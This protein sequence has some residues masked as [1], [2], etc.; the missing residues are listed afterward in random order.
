[1]KIARPRLLVGSLAV[2]ALVPAKAIE[3]YDRYLLDDLLDAAFASRALDTT[4]AWEALVTVRDDLLRKTTG[5]G[6]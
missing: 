2:A 5:D 1:V 4:G 6:R 3:K